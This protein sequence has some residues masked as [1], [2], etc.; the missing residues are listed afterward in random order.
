M[1]CSGPAP[2]GPRHP[3]RGP[4]AAILPLFPCRLQF[5]IPVGLNLLLMPGEHVLWRDIADGAVQTDVV[6]LLYVSSTPSVADVLNWGTSLTALYSAAR[7]QW[8]KCHVLLAR[9]EVVDAFISTH[10]GL[11][12]ADKA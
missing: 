9:I 10:L 11:F 3:S 5:P 6:E 1:Q 8:S 7:D 4:L 12:Q 2:G